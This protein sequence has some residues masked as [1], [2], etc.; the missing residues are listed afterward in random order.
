MAE[1]SVKERSSILMSQSGEQSNTSSCA[2]VRDS[3]KGWPH[4]VILAINWA[5]DKGPSK[6]GCVVANGKW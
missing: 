4:G 2:G 5:A 6:A 3:H 1:L